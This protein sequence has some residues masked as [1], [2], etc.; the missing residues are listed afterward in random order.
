MIWIILTKQNT[1]E[2]IYQSRDKA[3]QA[4]KLLGEGLESLYLWTGGNLPLVGQK[5]KAVSGEAY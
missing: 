2:S 5:V 1:V 3:T 4:L